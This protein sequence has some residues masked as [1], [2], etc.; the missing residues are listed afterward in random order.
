MKKFLILFIFTS[1]FSL[2]E[3]EVK[4]LGQGSIS[5]FQSTEMNNT[6]LDGGI[7]LSLSK[8]IRIKKYPINVNL[9][10]GLL[11]GISKKILSN[12]EEKKFEDKVKDYEEKISSSN[13]EEKEKL[14]LEKNIYIKSVKNIHPFI[15]PFILTEVSG[16]IKDDYK[17]YTGASL[18]S[19]HYIVNDKSI[20]KFSV[21]AK[22]GF[23]YK[24]RFTSE[25]SAG[26]PQ[27]F[28]LGIGSKFSF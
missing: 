24:N 11:G 27:Y 5:G 8:V 21:K 17:L 9:G 3:T 13:G 1:I 12:E 15:S 19:Y 18:G 6:S 16:K 10:T 4:V 7:E 25:I 26:Y 28:T 2:S 22:F 23:T 20:N 14:E